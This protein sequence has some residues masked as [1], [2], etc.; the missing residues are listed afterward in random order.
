[1]PIY[2]P[3]ATDARPGAATPKQGPERA[4]ASENDKSTMQSPIERLRASIGSVYLGNAEAVDRI[5]CCLI[6]KGHVLIEDV[7]GV[8]KTVLA[9]A[10]AR[11][12]NCPF[13]RIQ[14]TPDM[15]PGDILGVSIYRPGGPAP[16]SVDETQ[17]N[18][19]SGLLTGFAGHFEFKKGPIFANIVLADEIN[20]TPPRTQTAL[21]E[22]MN[23][24][25]VT[26]DGFTYRLDPPFMIV[27][28]QNPDDFEG[29]YLL[30]ENQLDRFLM[31]ISLGYPSPAD[32][33]RVLNQRPADNAL[34]A[35]KPVMSGAEVL[36]LQAQADG[37]RM[38]QTLVDYI[39][40]LANATRSAPELRVGLSPRGALALAHAARATAVLNRRDYV[41]PEDVIENVIPVCAH[42]IILRA[43]GGVGRQAGAAAADGLRRVL[44][45]IDSPA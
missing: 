25:T 21:L 32:E 22:A 37:V 18:G 38:E 30:P 39:I 24:S 40:A 15:L 4:G 16:S 31:R 5:I 7:P 41:I 13:S 14:L 23:E 2:S 43:A 34:Q 9:S 26:V 3:H 29:T 42:R 8:G 20:R 36:E 45:A 27:A 6:A 35:L 12:V 11:S 19:T 1:M 28:T 44:E 33:A 17:R 10:V